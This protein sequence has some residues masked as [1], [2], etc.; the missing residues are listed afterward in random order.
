M[1]RVFASRIN[2]DYR[3]KSLPSRKN[4]TGLDKASQ[5]RTE[6][7]IAHDRIARAQIEATDR[8]SRA[9]ESKKANRS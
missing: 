4:G 3:R 2:D 6:A 7:R 9:W 1:R 5:A 8:L